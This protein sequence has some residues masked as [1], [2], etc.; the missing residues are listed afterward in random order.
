MIRVFVLSTFFFLIFAGS[1]SADQRPQHYEGKA[2]DTLAVAFENLAETNT[3]IAQLVA[4][5]D[6]QPEELSELHQLTYTAENSL[7]KITEELEA[8]K[9]VLE[10]IHLSS[11][12]FDSAT[13]LKQ[14]PV[15][16]NASQELLGK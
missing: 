6:M 7:G 14:A 9:E 11:E 1:V 16:L 15:Y 8:L 13:V 10:V 2:A 12:D 5:G 4:D 3:R